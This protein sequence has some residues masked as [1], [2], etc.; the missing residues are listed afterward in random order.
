MSTLPG[1][2]CLLTDVETPSRLT[3]DRRPRPLAGPTD[4]GDDAVRARRAAT[5]G[6]T[7]ETCCT[8]GVLLGEA[9]TRRSKSGKT[10]CQICAD[11]AVAAYRARH[12]QPRPS[13]AR[14]C[15]RERTGTAYLRDRERYE[16]R[17]H[18][19]HARW[20]IAD[21]QVRR[22]T[23]HRHLTQAAAEKAATWMNTLWREQ[24]AHENRRG[25]A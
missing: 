20:Q 6:R 2:S 18:A 9:F 11:R 4:P 7:A 13:T 19:S 17:Y 3:A 12:P 1:T 21:T 5:T 22:W 16:V 8:C 25:D 14:P 10:F 23:S 24:V 15:G